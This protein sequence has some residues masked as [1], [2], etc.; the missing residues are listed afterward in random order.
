MVGSA[1]MNLVARTGQ[2]DI[3]DG[4]LK[5][6]QGTLANLLG[7]NSNTA[8][9]LRDNPMMA[10]RALSGLLASGTA[11]PYSRDAVAMQIA[12]IDRGRID[13][14]FT[15]PQQATENAV[16]RS[17]TVFNQFLDGGGLSLLGMS[18]EQL[19]QAIQNDPNFLQKAFKDGDRGSALQDAFRI[20]YQGQYGK[21]PSADDVNVTTE[22]GANLLKNNGTIDLNAPSVDGKTLADLIT[23]SQKTE[24]EKAREA[25]ADRH[26]EIMQFMNN[27][28][29]LLTNI[30]SSTADLMKNVNLAVGFLKPIAEQV[31]KFTGQQTTAQGVAVNPVQALGEKLQESD[32]G[33]FSLFGKGVLST[34]KSVNPA[35]KTLSDY[36][37]IGV[38][39][40]NP[41][42][43]AI[44]DQIGAGASN[45]LT[46]LIMGDQKQKSNVPADRPAHSKF[47]DT[48]SE[49]ILSQ[50]GFDTFQF[51][52]GDRVFASPTGGNDFG[53]RSVSLSFTIHQEFHGS[54]DAETV[55]SAAKSGI[56]AGR[57]QF[58]SELEAGVLDPRNSP[59]LRGKS[60]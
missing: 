54:A 46:K 25:Q 33:V 13:P 17:G 20:Q 19:S 5:T 37:K 55:R 57:D 11:E 24:G 6:I 29:G 9:L 38:S 60:H 41:I 30:D 48:P 14:A 3:G 10:S 18:R 36:F 58:L 34:E 42:T 7:G 2:A 39:A 49:G 31:S 1:R 21:L 27:F 59:R 28:S 52:H 51:A 8:Q 4:A 45:A 50:P 44:V 16:I 15:A 53:N 47:D 43:G 32:N 35:A 40:G 12:G 56:Q 22:I 23:E 26:K